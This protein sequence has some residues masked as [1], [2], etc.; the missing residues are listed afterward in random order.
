MY[1]CVASLY[2]ETLTVQDLIYIDE[3]DKIYRNKSISPQLTKIIIL[4]NYSRSVFIPFGANPVRSFSTRIQPNI[5]P[6]R[7]H[8]IFLSSPIHSQRWQSIAPTHS[9]LP[10]L[11]HSPCT[12]P[13]FIAVSRADISAITRLPYCLPDNSLHAHAAALA[14]ADWSEEEAQPYTSYLA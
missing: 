11:A 14:Q 8:H 5:S 6:R 13:W 12:F 2:N 1:Q 4:K 9:V 3:P 10:V 7:R